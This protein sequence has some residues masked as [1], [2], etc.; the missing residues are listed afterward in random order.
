MYLYLKQHILMVFELSTPNKFESWYHDFMTK[1]ASP[2]NKDESKISRQVGWCGFLHK[3]T[4]QVAC[5]SWTIGSI[6]QMQVYWYWTTKL[7]WLLV[8]LDIHENY[9]VHSGHRECIE[10]LVSVWLHKFRMLST[11]CDI[12]RL[13]TLHIAFTI[14]IY[15]KSIKLFYYTI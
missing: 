13:D 7:F 12:G 6:H 10:T 4:P 14:R 1:G 9:L 5:Q 15:S 8:N 11:A 2:A 3:K